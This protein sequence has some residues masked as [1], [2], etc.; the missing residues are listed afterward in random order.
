MSFS[1]SLTIPLMPDDPADFQEYIRICKQMHAKRVF[2]FT[3][4]DNI[5]RSPIDVPLQYGSDRILKAYPHQESCDIPSLEL[6]RVWSQQYRTVSEMFA[7]EGIESAYWIGETI[8][9]GGAISASHSPFMQL[10]GPEGL[11]T[12]GCNCPLDEDFLSY[13]EQVFGII[14][15]S[16]TPLI[17][18]DDDFRLNYHA[19]NVTMGCFC[20]LHIAEFNRRTGRNMTREEIVAAVF[21]ETPNE[22]RSQWFD[23]TGES[24]IALAA[25]IEQAVHRV[26]PA[27]RIGLATAMTHWSSEGVDLSRLLHT[28]AGNTRPFVRTFGSPYRHGG[29]LTHISRVTEFSRMQKDK[30]LGKEIEILAEGDTYPHTRFFCPTSMFNA[31]QQGLLALGFGDILSYPVTFSARATHEPGYANITA[32]HLEN[33]ARISELFDD[34]EA[35]GLSPLWCENNI[36]NLTF[37]PG[38][39]PKDFIWPDEPSGMYFPARMGVPVGAG[40]T[41]GPVILTG[42]NGQKLTDDQIHRLL[43]RGLILDAPAASDLLSRGFDIGITSIHPAEN[44]RFER[45]LGPK[46]SGRHTGETIWLLTN[47]TNLYYRA[48]AVPEAEVLSEFRGA[49]GIPFPAVIRYRNKK[50]QQVLLYSFD[51]TLATKG[52]QLVHNYARQEQLA[53]SAETLGVGVPVTAPGYPDLHLI[54][55]KRQD[56]RLVLAVQNSHLDPIRELTLRLDPGLE[57]PE[58]LT[59]LPPDADQFRQAEYTT[60][61]S[62]GRLL[63]TLREEIPAMGMLCILL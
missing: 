51:M 9:H 50:D 33:Y 6:Y 34:S 46:T 52:G 41:D 23:C 58:T 30:F 37:A 4:L 2:L 28:L 39:A 27:A 31:Y 60:H 18:L 57:L 63:L 19:P 40:K 43:D 8:G 12:D 35:V 47:G 56:G 15:E 25:R 26:N 32:E 22:I 3:P 53:R 1:C 29:N 5:C 24:L 49:D 61:L 62:D 20:P 16:G 13:M 36:R 17:L 44:A 48:E 42:G 11:Q 55:R 7:A 38:V 45:F 59:V 14:A 54:C 21:S 10:T